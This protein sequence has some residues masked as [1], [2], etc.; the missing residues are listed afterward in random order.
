[1][2]FMHR[3]RKKIENEEF[4]K[5]TFS[6]SSRRHEHELWQIF[7]LE[8]TA[9]AGLLSFPQKLIVSIFAQ[10]LFITP[11]IKILLSSPSHS[12]FNIIPWRL[13]SMR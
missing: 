5:E 12:H 11:H 10:C 9:T 4:M 8:I 6:H 3:E 7:S 2:L 13:C 1:M